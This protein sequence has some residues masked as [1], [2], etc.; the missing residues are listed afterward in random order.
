MPQ[1]DKFS[2]V[3]RTLEVITKKQSETKR[4][5]EKSSSQT[6]II[7]KHVYLILELGEFLYLISTFHWYSI[8]CHVG[9]P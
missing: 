1:G 9:A 2:K 5:Q 7:H 8:L 4:Q 3:Q 6:A